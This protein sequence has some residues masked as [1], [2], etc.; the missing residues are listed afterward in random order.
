MNYNIKLLYMNKYSFK[1][2]DDCKNSIKFIKKGSFKTIIKFASSKDELNELINYRNK[3]N[4]KSKLKRSLLKINIHDINNNLYKLKYYSQQN[5]KSF[6]NTLFYLFYKLGSGIFVKIMNNKIKMFYPFYNLNYVNNFDLKF[7]NANSFKEFLLN[8]R[9]DNYNMNESEWTANGCIIHPWK[10]TDINDGRWAEFYDMFDT[11]CNN[12]QINDVEFFIN[13]KDFPSL[14]INLHEPNF[15]VFDKFNKELNC[16]KYNSYT[17]IL[18]CY[19]SPLYA[20]IQI[21]SYT[22]WKMITKAFYPSSGYMACE[23]K[24]ILVNKID[25]N[26]KIPTA[27]FRG[28][29]TGCGITTTTNQRLH[30]SLISHKWKSNNLYNENNSVDGIPFLNAGIMAF[31][32]KHK[33]DYKN[34]VDTIN[35]QLLGFNKIKGLSRDEQQQYKY[36]IYI[37]G[38][39]AA[40]RLITELDSGNLILKVESFYNWTQWFHVFLRPYVHYIPIKKDL[41]D[42]ADKIKWCK[43]H[44]NECYEITQNA[45]SLYLKLNN[46]KLT[47]NYLKSI[48]DNISQLQKY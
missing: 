35:T 10:I 12:K 26:N 25:W 34:P 19:S 38:H 31:N 30:I 42:L 46:K 48:V 44:D 1:S 33:K 21:P 45:K 2:S 29:A 22:E 24:Q 37:D 39:V 27:I 14:N 41:S 15:F 11:L 28:S 4:S 5:S 23:N 9:V 32:A 36:V 20:D 16:H 6:Q 3:F 47:L 13:Y 8:K 18:S 40:E 17:P 7:K 43:T